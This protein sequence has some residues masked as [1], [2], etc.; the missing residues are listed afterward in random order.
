MKV[1]PKIRWPVFAAVGLLVLLV[2]S[3]ILQEAS[4]RPRLRPGVP[5]DDYLA[6]VHAEEATTKRKGLPPF[7]DLQTFISTP[8]HTRHCEQYYFRRG[9]YFLT[10]DTIFD[11]TNRTFTGISLSHWQWNF[12]L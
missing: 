4:H 3:F 7:R 5:V 10:H 8:Y 6:Y 11:F 12:D 9:H 2:L 1:W